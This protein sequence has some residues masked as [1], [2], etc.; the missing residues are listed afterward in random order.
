[1]LIVIGLHF[2]HVRKLREFLLIL[3]IMVTLMWSWLNL[4]VCRTLELFMK[5]F[6]LPRFINVISE[7][8]PILLF[9]FSVLWLV[10]LSKTGERLFNTDDTEFDTENSMKNHITNKDTFNVTMNIS[11]Y[12]KL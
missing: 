1:M 5:D 9:V 11:K 3:G 2:I 4:F 6:A 8:M 7:I 12:E 10:K